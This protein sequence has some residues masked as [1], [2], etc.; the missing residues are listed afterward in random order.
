MSICIFSVGIPPFITYVSVLE[1]ANSKQ[2]ELSHNY[3]L[4]I[5]NRKFHYP[6]IHRRELASSTNHLSL[7]Q[8]NRRA[9]GSLLLDPFDSP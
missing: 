1:I 8:P 4:N 3:E 2:S 7:A 6:P 5:V 9:H